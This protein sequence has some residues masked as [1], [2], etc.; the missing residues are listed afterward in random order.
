MYGGIAVSYSYPQGFFDIQRDSLM[1]RLVCTLPKEASLASL[2]SIMIDIT[3]SGG[4]FLS[5]FI[6]ATLQLCVYGY[7]LSHIKWELHATKSYESV[8]LVKGKSYALIRVRYLATCADYALQCMCP[9]A[10]TPYVLKETMLE[11][12]AAMCG[13][14]KDA[15]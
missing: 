15:L 5:L 9:E 7:W 3:T 13:I 2:R 1:N 14:R 4:T 8:R 12:T 10:R 11:A 6:S